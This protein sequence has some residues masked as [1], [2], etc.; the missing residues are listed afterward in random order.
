M[1]NTFKMATS[2]KTVNYLVR[3]GSEAG[4]QGLDN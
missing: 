4:I 1:N 2:V 3:M